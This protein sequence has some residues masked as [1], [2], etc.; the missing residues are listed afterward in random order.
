M[1]ASFYIFRPSFFENGF[2]STTTNRSMAYVMPHICF[3]L[4]QPE[5]FMLMELMVKQNLLDFE[6]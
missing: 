2:E 4:D 1:N 5:D 6:F 3:D